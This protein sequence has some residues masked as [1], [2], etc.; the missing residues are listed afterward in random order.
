MDFINVFK[1]AKPAIYAA[2][3]L[4]NHVNVSFHTFAQCLETLEVAVLD[5]RVPKAKLIVFREKPEITLH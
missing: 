2:E 4:D 5:F 3:S 1:D